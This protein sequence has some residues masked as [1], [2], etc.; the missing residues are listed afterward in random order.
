MQTYNIYYESA[1]TFHLLPMEEI[2]RAKS[3]LIQI[4]SGNSSRTMLEKLIRE[5][6]VFFP[7]AVIVGVTTGGE[8]SDRKMTSH[9]IL[10][11]ISAFKK[12]KVTSFSIDAITPENSF[13][14][15]SILAQKL[16]KKDTKLLILYTEGLYVNADDFLAGVGETAPELPVCGAVAADNGK[17]FETFVLHD[18]KVLSR[19]AV[20]IALSGKSLNIHS[21]SLTDWE[22]IGPL[23]NITKSKKNRVYEINGK[24]S[25]EFFRHYLGDLFIENLPESGFDISLT[26]EAEGCIFNRNVVAVARDGALVFTGNV[27]E[28]S[29][30]R[31]GYLERNGPS[32]ESLHGLKI[33]DDTDIES[34][35]VF[36]GI[37]RKRSLKEISSRQIDL[38]AKSASVSG[39]FGY[40][41]FIHT[42]NRN[43][44]LNQSC[45]II[46][47]SEGK[48]SSETKSVCMVVQDQKGYEIEKTL[49]HLVT[50]ANEELEQKS[51][52]LETL[53]SYL[54]AGAIFFDNDLQVT[55][56]NNLALN[57]L[58]LEQEKSDFR[59]LNRLKA[60]WIVSMFRETLALNETISG[61]GLTETSDGKQ[62]YIRIKTVPMK[63]E[64]KTVG[65]MAL[66]QTGEKM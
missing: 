21:A 24:K 35:F 52:E 46:G 26:Y 19:G 12:T 51:R 25:V 60:G 58:G 10:I 11:S 61:G 29:R 33:F 37:G 50:V 55:L 18:D 15:G 9:K 41:E 53:L 28:G 57:L 2:N 1:L 7:D 5:A 14:A 30:C 38:F 48:S 4:F 20:G 65:A 36:S 43:C 6:K 32:K 64:G 34:F 44:L 66:I 54:P 23:L 62:L 40:G 45:S 27:P 16:V 3:V 17:F 13:D 47:L 56:Y 42:D 8:I 59:D 22:A 49:A 39:F 31:F 63:Q